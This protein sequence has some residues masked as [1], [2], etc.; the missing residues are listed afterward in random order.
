MGRRLK[1]IYDE[2]QVPP[3]PTA[4][5]K[6]LKR[7]QSLELANLRNKNLYESYYV[8]LTDIV[9]RFIEDK[10]QLPATSQTTDEF[11]QG[12]A[13]NPSFE[14]QTKYLLTQFLEYADK[15][16]FAQHQPSSEDVEKAYDAAKQ[17]ITA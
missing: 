9:R 4:E 8:E 11:L 2:K 16:K 10:Y 13:Q 12:A 7:L 14:P 17:I 3:E 6:A 5:Q 15:V 1:R